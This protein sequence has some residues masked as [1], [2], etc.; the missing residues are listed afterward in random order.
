[1]QKPDHI[2]HCLIDSSIYVHV[3]A[4]GETF[5]KRDGVTI[6]YRAFPESAHALAW[7]NRDGDYKEV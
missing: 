1:M 2:F 5:W 3:Y 7:L 4:S 6:M